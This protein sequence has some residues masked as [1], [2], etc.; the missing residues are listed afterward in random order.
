M[1]LTPLTIVGWALV[2]LGCSYWFASSHPNATLGKRI[3]V[4]LVSPFALS[5]LL[6]ILQVTLVLMPIYAIAG[7]M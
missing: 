5:P 4:F 6:A 7:G 2:G 1:L 3:A